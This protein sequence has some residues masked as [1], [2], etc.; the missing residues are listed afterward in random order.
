LRVEDDPE[1]LAELRRL[2]AVH[3]AYGL[4]DWAD[5]LVGAGRHQE[6]ADLYRQASALAPGNHELRFWAGLGA[7]QGGDM[8]LAVTEVQAA[9]TA[10]P[11]WRILL[12]RLPAHVAPS[13]RAVLSRLRAESG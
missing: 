3:E 4:A 10:H 9:I 1:P 2:R 6:A 5:E 11:P 13:A 7:A 12:E 8:D